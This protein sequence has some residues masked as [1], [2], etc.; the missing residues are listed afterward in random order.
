MTAT[1]WQQGEIDA[2][3][4]FRDGS[5]ANLWSPQTTTDSNGNFISYDLAGHFTDTLGINVLTISG[6]APN[7][8]SY[9]YTDTTGVARS[10]V[11]N[12]TNYTVQTNFGA[13]GIGEYGPQVNPLVSSIVYPDGS[14]YSFTYEATPGFPGA[15]LT[16]R[17]AMER[18]RMCIIFTT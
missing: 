13:P 3:V 12:Y 5:V 7:P 17:I 16:L 1:E 14:Q 9:T 4:A 2:R 15:P 18:H 11:V 8:V 6:T 10:V